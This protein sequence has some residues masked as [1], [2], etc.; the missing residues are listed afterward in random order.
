MQHPYTSGSI[1][2]IISAPGPFPEHPTLG[3]PLQGGLQPRDRPHPASVPFPLLRSNGVPRML[4][5]KL[6]PT[7]IWF[8]LQ[9]CCFKSEGLTL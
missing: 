8:A 3:V 4:H 7:E 5:L 9:R 2:G 6:I 1:P